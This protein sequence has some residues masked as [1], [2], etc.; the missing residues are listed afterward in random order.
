MFFPKAAMSVPKKK[1]NMKEL[2]KKGIGDLLD[3][4]TEVCVN[5]N[6]NMKYDTE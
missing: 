5:L 3:A 1:K 4:F 6:D 2:N